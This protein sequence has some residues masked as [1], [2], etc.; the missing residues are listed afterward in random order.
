MEKEKKLLVLVVL[1]G[2]VF[3]LSGSFFFPL[4][5]GPDEP[6]HFFYLSYIGENGELPA[7]PLTQETLRG[8]ENES[9]HQPPLYYLLMA[10]FYPVLKPFGVETAVHA[11]RLFSV[12]FGTACIA[13][14]YLIAKRIGFGGKT[15]LASAAFLALLPTHVVSSSFLGNS[16]LSWLLCLAAVYYLAKVMQ[17]KR[18]LHMAI[19]GVFM[20]AIVLTKFT[21][22][23]VAVAFLIAGWVFLF[24]G[25]GSFAKRAAL[26]LVPL[27]ALPVFLRNLALTGGFFP[28]HLTVKIFSLERFGYF[29]VHLFPSVWLQEY[30]AASIPDFR[31]LFFGLYAVLSAVAFFGVVSLFRGNSWPGKNGFAVT[32]LLVFPVVLNFLGLAYINLEGM[33]PDGRLLFETIGLAAILFV[34]GQ[35]EFMRLAGFESRAGVLVWETLLTMLFLDLVVLVNYNRVL[36]A[37]PWPLF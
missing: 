34:A 25:R 17:E 5:G 37:V 22:L 12:A 24:Q 30:G 29:L 6:A 31:F 8:V 13:L 14:V 20:A 9:I 7:I 27:A 4:W 19:A 32:A 35:R 26:L 1:I 28:S 23:S 21:G 36:P 10:P 18:A 11:L 33:W 15:A 2:L 3:R 16:A